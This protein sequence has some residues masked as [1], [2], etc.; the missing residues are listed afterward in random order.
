MGES[1]MQDVPD[2]Q[3]IDRWWEEHAEL[4]RMV[5]SVAEALDGGA[6]ETVSGALEE[7]A[8][9]LEGHFSVEELTYFPLI[10]Q[11]S[12]RHASAVAGA[13]LGHAKLRERLEDLR[14]LVEVGELSAA[15][16]GLGVLLARFRDHE[17]EEEKMV[18]ALKAVV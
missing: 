13:R 7:L 4:A 15:R 9:A 14:D 12:A 2:A 10:E 6:I 1:R 8:D 11:F 5:D 16:R 18:R 17:E 3:G